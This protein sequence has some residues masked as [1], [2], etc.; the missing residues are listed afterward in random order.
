[1]VLPFLWL[2]VPQ[3]LML[4]QLIVINLLVLHS[5]A[6][7]DREEGYEIGESKQGALAN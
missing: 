3:P 5:G 6:T 1:M 2:P 4:Q 7:W